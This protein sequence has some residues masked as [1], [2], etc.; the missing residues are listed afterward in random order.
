MKKSKSLIIGYLLAFF[1]GGVGA[2]LFYYD[3]RLR[4]WIYFLAVIFSAAR[5]LPLTMVLG[6][7]DMFFIKKWHKEYLER[8]EKISEKLIDIPTRFTFT[9]EITQVGK[10]EPSLQKVLPKK[11]EKKFYKEEDIILPEYA[12]LKT[13]IHIRKD[14][15]KLRNSVN[16]KKTNSP[17]IEI[18]VFTRD[19]EFMKDSIRYADMVVRNADFVPLEVYWTTFRDLDERQK[20]WYFYWRYQALNGNYLDTDLSYVILFVYELI[21]Y[22][23]NQNAAFN[24]S[25]MVRLR[26]AYKDRLPALDKYIVPWIRDILVELNEIELA[27]KWGL[28]AEPYSGLNF[29][30]IFKEHQ[31]DISKIP[32]EEWR[33]VVY[34]YSETTFFKAN[35]QKVYAVFE[36]A[37]KLFQ[38]INAEEGLD[39]EKAWF[40]PEEKIE[41]YRFFNSAVIGRNVSSR[42]IKYLKYVPTDYFYN[43]VTALFRLS[44]NVTRLLA[45]VTRQLQ[46]NEELLPPGFKE[47]LLEEIRRLD[48]TENVGLK[49]RFSPDKKIKNRFYQV[50]SKEN[51]ESKQTIPKRT[52]QTIGIGSEKIKPELDLL[53]IDIPAHRSSIS[54]ADE[55]VNV[56]GFISS[57]TEE[58][59]KFISTFSNNK[60]SI[61]EAEEQ[62]RAQGVPV[63]I[64]VEQIN[65]K[66]EE[67][68]EDVFIELIGE[69][70]VINEEL[71]T[72]W[73]EIKRR[74]QHEN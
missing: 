66:A 50:A 12:H 38:K 14:I 55:E 63:T 67:Y 3:K 24:V 42:V 13:P 2:H 69:E 43:E 28:G 54:L 8:G 45:G 39:L 40:R 17:A 18:N 11:E 22:T 1:L 41:N 56:E 71:V 21:N 49:S 26:E 64:F 53:Q 4:A 27:Y 52:T 23:F 57:L 37:L 19:T 44:E 35:A 60:K 48:L 32:M 5:L 46:V 34:G 15:E 16:A 68:L 58:E 62:L 9:T 47:A 10:L 20:K 7:I 6:W 72:V 61:N 33:K 74:K 51:E 59:S 31:G 70:Y 36:Q 30:R 65:A 73:E 29:Y 25:M